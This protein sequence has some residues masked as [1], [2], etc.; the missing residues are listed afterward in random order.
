MYHYGAEET[1]EMSEQVREVCKQTRNADP[2]EG[3]Y[4][5]NGWILEEGGVTHESHIVDLQLK[6]LPTHIRLGGQDG[7]KDD[8]REPLGGGGGVTFN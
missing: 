6:L 8:V 7:G 2:V 5:N 3:V 4:L 1:H